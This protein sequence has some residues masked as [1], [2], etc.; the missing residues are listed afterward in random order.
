MLLVAYQGACWWPSLRLAVGLLGILLVAYLAACWW[1]TYELAAG[2]LPGSLLW[3]SSTV[4]VSVVGCCGGTVTAL[5][6]STTAG[7]NRQAQPR[8]GM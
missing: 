4:R 8:P 6:P 5:P 1:R 7:V 2:A 3:T